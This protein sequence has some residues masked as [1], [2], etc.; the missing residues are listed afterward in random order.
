MMA[1]TQLSSQ[2]AGG[3][4]W[5]G[6]EI[7]FIGPQLCFLAFQTFVRQLSDFTTLLNKNK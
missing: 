5:K 1:R 7:C 4:L 6:G 2:S 3:K